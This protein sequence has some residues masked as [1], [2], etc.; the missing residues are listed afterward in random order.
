MVL[1]LVATVVVSCW[2]GFAAAADAPD[3]VRLK[4]GGMLRGTIIELVPG[5]SVDILL[6]GGERRKLDMAGVEYAGPAEPAPPA[7]VVTPAPT[8]PPIAPAPAVPLEQLVRVESKT[9]NLSL[10]RRTGTAIASFSSAPGVAVAQASYWDNLCD[11]LPCEISLPLG[12][13]NL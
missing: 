8:A 5:K 6:L 2:V 11:G 12:R 3:I 1:R 13:H 9:P 7:S 4:D 10:H